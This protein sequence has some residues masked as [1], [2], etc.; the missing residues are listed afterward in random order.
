MS[1][2]HAMIQQCILRI[3]QALNVQLNAILHHPL[4][5][6][7]EA[8]WRGIRMLSNE[9]QNNTKLSIKLLNLPFKAFCCDLLSNIEFDQTQLFRKIYSHEFDLAGGQPFNLL[10]G[11]YDFSH[12]IVEQQAHT[13]LAL[14]AMSKIA[15]AAF[16]PFISAAHPSLFGLDHYSELKSTL[17]LSGIFKQAEYHAWQSLR[18]DPDM[19]FIGLCLPHILMRPPYN[20]THR[21]VPRSFVE[22]TPQGH[23]YLWG[24]PAYAFGVVVMR[25]F[26]NSNWFADICGLPPEDQYGGRLST[27][28][29]L[30]KPLL[31]GQA[32]TDCYLTDQMERHLSE[33]GFLP[34]KDQPLNHFAVFYHCQ[35]LY[36]P[37]P[38]HSSPSANSKISSMLHY[39]LCASRFAHYIKIL[40]REKIGGFINAQDC[41]N[42]LQR[43]LLSY[44]TASLTDSPETKARYPLRQAKVKVEA[45]AGS[46]GKYRC[47]LLLQPHY[48]LDEI[49]SELCLI[50]HLTL[51]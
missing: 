2:L 25:A 37:A 24:N 32:A 15:A 29:R 6:R 3:D 9:A 16:A 17:S 12:R 49:H 23:A 46:I 19:R 50:T 38:A 47:I 18:T 10:I 26:I 45:I 48:Q 40:M 33:W 43:W 42:F 31:L 41:E 27:L 7:L 36:T 8:S 35:S 51:N 34:L 28:P 5:Q 11:D 20:H 1:P 30:P 4:L 39:I 21:A 22:S 13:L 44:S 14:Q